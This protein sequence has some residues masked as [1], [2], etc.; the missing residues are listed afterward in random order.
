MNV[1]PIEELEKMRPVGR[2]IAG[3][4]VGT[5][6][7][8]VAI[9]DLGLSFAVPRT[10][11]KRSKFSRDAETLL[12][13]LSHENVGAVIVGLPVNMNGTEG[14]RAQATRAF[15]RNLAPM[16]DLLFSFWDERLSTVA[17]ERALVEMDV[18][19][20]KRAER[21]DSSAAAFILQGALDR[22][23]ALRAAARTSPE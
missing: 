7:I 2:P 23:E 1:V 15:V 4:D 13:L 22:L 12:R 16:T 6:T 21:I 8:G 18:S 5:K 10:V 3:L 14:P 17:A 19:R 20:K 11:I 9:S